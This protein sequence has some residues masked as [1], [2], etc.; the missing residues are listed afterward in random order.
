MQDRAMQAV[1][2]LALDPVVE[3]KSDPHSYG[4]WPERS[5]Q[6]AREQCFNALAKKNQAHW[7]LEADIKG[8]F[9]HAC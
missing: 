7:V 4:F 6:D 9:D 1:Y 3:T 5:T 2:S 8:C